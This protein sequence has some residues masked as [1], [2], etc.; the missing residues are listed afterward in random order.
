MGGSLLVTSQPRSGTTIAIDLP[1]L[2]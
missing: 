2:A 1:L